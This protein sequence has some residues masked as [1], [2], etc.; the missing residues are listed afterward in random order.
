MWTVFSSIIQ[1]CWNGVN[2]FG[3]TFPKP[4]DENNENNQSELVGY[5]SFIY[6]KE[7]LIDL[8]MYHNE[9]NRLVTP[10]QLPFLVINSSFTMA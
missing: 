10:N 3:I 2:T 7:E 8:E 5:L 1:Y 9:A 4:R 6:S